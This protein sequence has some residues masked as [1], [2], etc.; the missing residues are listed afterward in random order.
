[1][2]ANT[3]S[4]LNFTAAIIGPGGGFQLGSGEGAAE[5]GVS[6]SL[7]E[8]ADRMV[9]GADG[10]PMHSLNASK[11]G[12]VTIRLLKTS[13]TNGRLSALYNFQRLS[14]VNWAQNTILLTDVVRGDVYSCQSVAFTKFPDNKYGKD[15]NILEWEFTAGIIDPLLAIVG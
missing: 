12:R 13:L 1:M 6:V 8:E 4:F 14:S 5:E 2:A 9:I 7:S 3:Y 15:A 10:T 11:A